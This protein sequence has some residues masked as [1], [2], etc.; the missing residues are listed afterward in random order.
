M[1]D[2]IQYTK[3]AGAL[4]AALAIGLGAMG[5]ALAQGMVASKACENI[6][7]YPES[8]QNIRTVMLI[9]LG[10]IETSAIYALLIAGG[11]L[12]FVAR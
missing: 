3:A 1:E 9:A 11:L 6:G 4:G 5:P 12:M 10:L 7:K 2:I 8:A